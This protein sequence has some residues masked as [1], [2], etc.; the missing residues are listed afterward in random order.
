MAQGRVDEPARRG[1]GSVSTR[2]RWPAGV[3]VA[4]MSPLGPARAAGFRRGRRDR[5]ASTARQ[6]ASQEEFYRELWQAPMDQ[7]VQR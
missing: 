1:P 3:V 6:V 2:S 7:D 4:G 5:P